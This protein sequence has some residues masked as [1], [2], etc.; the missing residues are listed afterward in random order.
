[1]TPVFIWQSGRRV[2][3]SVHWKVLKKNGELTRIQEAFI[4]EGAIQCGFCTPG[5]LVTVVSTDV[6]FPFGNE[7]EKG[8]T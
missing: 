4:E 2:K 1:M 6:P 5:F 7:R 3:I 8:K